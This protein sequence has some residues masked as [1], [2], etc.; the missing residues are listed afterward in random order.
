ML[1]N[2]LIK[3]KD[4]QLILLE[5]ENNNL[6]NKLQDLNEKIDKIN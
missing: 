6:K 1:K 5:N 4:D 3:I 2:Y